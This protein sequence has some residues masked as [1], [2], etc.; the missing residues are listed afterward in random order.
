MDMP[1]PIGIA[2]GVNKKATHF[3]S[4][5]LQLVAHVTYGSYTL[6][7][8]PGNPEPNADFSD[9]TGAGGNCI[10]LRNDGLAWLLA[11]ELHQLEELHANSDA[12]LGISFAP[13]ET[14]EVRTICERVATHI[15]EYDT[16]VNYWEFNGSCPNHQARSDIAIL[17][18]DVDALGTFLAESE[19]LQANKALKIAPRTAT[20]TLRA[21]VELCGEHGFS[22]LVS[23]NT[24]KG[25]FTDYGLKPLHV[26]EGGISGRPLF[27][28]ARKQAD[29]LRDL[30]DRYNPRL[31]LRVGGGI[32]TVED[33]M[34]MKETGADSLEVASL[35]Y[36]KNA[37]VI[38]NLITSAALQ[39]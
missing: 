9:K 20:E 33:V 12:A 11:T 37:S 32:Q 13:R 34:L 23:G 25:R 6:T 29:V 19:A 26:E 18:Q 14:G 36:F 10:K 31:H 2:A 28:Y 38:R 30:I 5:L 15:A 24:F 7:F 17:S 16:T 1:I 21:T 35:L 39:S 22:M 4:P 3:H 27:E 8:E